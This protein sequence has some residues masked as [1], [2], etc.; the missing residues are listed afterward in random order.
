MAASQLA[1]LDDLDSGPGELP[2]TEASPGYLYTEGQRLALE[3]LLSEGAEA[4]ENC[5]LQERL[6]PFLSADEVRVLAASAED[7]TTAVPEPSGAAEGAALTN[8]LASDSL[9][10][11][12]GQSEE[13]APVLR[14]GWPEDPAWK[15]ITRAQLYTQPPAEGHPSLKEVV[16]RELQ[17]A[18][19]LVAVV[20]DVF[21]DPD[22]LWDLV[23]AATRRWVPVYL[24]LDGQQLPAFLALARQLRVN[25][26]ATENLDVRVGQG[27]SF[28]SRRRR[29]VS[30]HMREKFVLLDSVRVITGSYS[31]ASTC[32][33]A[34]SI[35][36]PEGL[37]FLIW[38]EGTKSGT[39]GVQSL[40]AI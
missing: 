23:D 37:R 34:L 24:L 38:K 9:T 3:T 39:M 13:P 35:P 27:C 33:F 11:W 19:K 7:W 5:V 25:P 2:L 28:Q 30:G 4:F 36:F 18:S 6:R 10:Y 32:R 15:G 12:P 8:G 20:M 17:A 21:T 26:W 1:A 40:Q 31:P 14:L 16:R 29:Q 22:L